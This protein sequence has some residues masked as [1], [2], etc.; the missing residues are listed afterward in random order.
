MPIWPQPWAVRRV[1]WTNGSNALRKNWPLACHWSKSCKVTRVHVRHQFPRRIPSWFKR[2][3]P[4]VISR[5]KA[6]GASPVRKQSATT[7]EREPVLPF[8]QLS[9]PSCKT[10]YRILKAND[11]IPKRGKPVHEPLERPG[12]MR[13]WQIDFK[14]VSSVPADPDGKRQHLV[15]T[16]N[17]ID[18]GTGAYFLTLMC[19]PISARKRPCR[20][21]R[22]HWQGMVGRSRVTLDRD[23]ALW[24]AV[25]PGSDFP[26]ALV[27][28][29]RLAWALR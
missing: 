16:L 8:F 12:P 29:W 18:T 27:R 2:S 13:D 6:C 15:E 10:I 9:V 5:L 23:P 26:A 4:F 1:G 21:W 7:R 24:L 14:D 20:L 17:I 11:R 25:Q 22:P 19:V 3:S 28:G